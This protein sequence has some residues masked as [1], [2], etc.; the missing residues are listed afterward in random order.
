MENTLT[1][2]KFFLHILAIKGK[3][4]LWNFLAICFCFVFL[5]RENRKNFLVSKA[6]YP[7]GTILNY[8]RGK[9]S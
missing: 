4:F 6:D 9:D 3:Q 8:T 1:A 5:R 2:C 7:Q